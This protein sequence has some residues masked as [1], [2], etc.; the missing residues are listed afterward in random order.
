MKFIITF[1]IIQNH[2]FLFNEEGIQ[3]SLFNGAISKIKRE[4]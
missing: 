3:L 1:L 2:S 4:Y